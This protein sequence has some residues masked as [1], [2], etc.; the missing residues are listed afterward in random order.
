[1]FFFSRGLSYQLV[2]DV[3]SS[4]DPLCDGILGLEEAVLLEMRQPPDE[5][6]IPLRMYYYND[7]ADTNLTVTVRG[8]EVPAMG[9][10]AAIVTDTVNICGDVLNGADKI[11]FR[12]IQTALVEGDEIERSDIWAVKITNATYIV[13]NHFTD[14]IQD[15][16][17]EN[18]GYDQ[19]A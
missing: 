4:D 6:W 8:Y 14:L 17:Q 11:Q 10:R 9:R 15:Y 16:L 19:A 5:D 7:T 13:G 12:W 18:P 2:L 1:M 3:N